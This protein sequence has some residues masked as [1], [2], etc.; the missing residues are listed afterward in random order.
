R[1]ELGQLV[2]RLVSDAQSGVE[3]RLRGLL[4]R[5]EEAAE[6]S[7]GALRGRIQTYMEPKAPQRPARRRAAAARRQHK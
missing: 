5:G 6:R 7:I 1:H 4:S 3:S 2:H